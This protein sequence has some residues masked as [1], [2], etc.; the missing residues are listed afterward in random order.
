MRR[1]G[2][3]DTADRVALRKGSDREGYRWHRLNTVLSQP[4]EDETVQIDT[5]T[6]SPTTPRSGK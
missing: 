2:P 3:I 5:A 4:P 1:V 6:A